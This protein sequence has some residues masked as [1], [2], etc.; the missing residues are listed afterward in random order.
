MGIFTFTVACGVA[1][2]PTPTPTETPVP[3][4]CKNVT[5]Y[6]SDFNAW[7]VYWY[8]CYNNFQTTTVPAYS[9]EYLVCAQQNSYY[10]FSGGA[11]S[12]NVIGDCQYP[13]NNCAP[14]PTP[15]P[16][17]TPTNT[18]FP[19]PTPL[20]NY[21]VGV[22]AR[23]GGTPTCIIPPGGG[24]ET[25]FRVYYWLG[26]PTTMQLLG[27]SITSNTCTFVGNITVPSG[28]TLYLGCRSWSYNTPIRYNVASGTTTCPSA[29]SQ[30]CG[31]AYDNGGALCYQQVI[32]ANTNIAITADIETYT[33]YADGKT[34]VSSC[35]RFVYC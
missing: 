18:P 3:Y 26:S 21:T 30:Y 29:G 17:F 32:T 2:T 15:T 11:I 7:D 16:S 20:P 5:A 1:P 19:T 14:T 31:T 33:I 10:D 35:Q 22:Y 8:D 24:A 25:Q 4:C 13:N 6:N 28:K 9:T 23:R 12:Y 27:G 34:P